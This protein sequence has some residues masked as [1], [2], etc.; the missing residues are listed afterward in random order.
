MSVNISIQVG[1]EEA[2]FSPMPAMEMLD[3]YYD[4][5][6]ITKQAPAY[7]FPL[8]PARPVGKSTEESR[9]DY[10]PHFEVVQPAQVVYTFPL[11]GRANKHSDE[12]TS[13]HAVERKRQFKL[14][15]S[16][17]KE[18]EKERAAA[19]ERAQLPHRVKFAN[20][21]GREAPIFVQEPLPTAHPT[22]DKPLDAMFAPLEKRAAGGKFSKMSRSVMVA[23]PKLDGGE[24]ALSFDF[25][26]VKAARNTPGVN[27]GKTSGRQSAYA[28]AESNRKRLT[29]I[30]RKADRIHAK[31]NPPN[32]ADLVQSGLS[33]RACT[34][35]LYLCLGRE[36][37]FN[38][39][40]V[41][42]SESVRAVLDNVSFQ[43]Q[44][45]RNDFAVLATREQREQAARKRQALNSAQLSILR[46][47]D[48]Y[49][50]QKRYDF[51]DK[52]LNQLKD[53]LTG[54]DPGHDPAA[55]SFHRM[56]VRKGMR[57]LQKEEAAQRA[58]HTVNAA[59]QGS[60]GGHGDELDD[61]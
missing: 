38:G 17:L 51:E 43:T 55:G 10:S 25:P 56:R 5:Q 16:R 9:F 37:P 60:P 1:R 50:L 3:R 59:L 42:E 57:E 54:F 14:L 35:D 28:H 13:K 4:A 31:E 26:T 18:E 23:L 20:T 12:D 32:G 8:A 53:E 11:S 21:T 52:E 34:P 49:K 44:R 39:E 41:P 47:T 61:I 6:P 15:Q 27:I 58:A 29:D 22:P 33:T 2:H 36:A 24:I 19:Q 48:G 7:T 45:L 46:A 40:V 30:L